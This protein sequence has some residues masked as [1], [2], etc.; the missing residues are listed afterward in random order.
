[1]CSEAK[2]RCWGLQWD[3]VVVE[4]ASPIPGHLMSPAPIR[5]PHPLTPHTEGTGV[6]LHT[7]ALLG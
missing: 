7:K 4:T 1:M 6:G 5:A 3:L 2:G